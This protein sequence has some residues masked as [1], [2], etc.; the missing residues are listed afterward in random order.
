[1]LRQLEEELDRVAPEALLLGGDLI[2]FPIGYSNL[3]DWVG[4]LSSRFPVM[5]VPGNHDRWAGV[6]RLKRRLDRVHW[7]DD[8]PLQLS[9]GLRLCGRPDQGATSSSLLVG[10]EPDRVAE[11]A[12]YGFPL[13]LA[14]H[15]HG[16]QWIAYQSKGLDYPGAWFFAH[17]G[18]RFQVGPTTL[19]VSRGI[20]DTLP[21]RIHCP[22]DYLLLELR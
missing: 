5:A 3:I 2:D 8:S 11:A 22:R 13:M 1:M 16:C 19:H 10:H 17:H 14:G 18:E 7:L 20:S 4:R 15:L 9:N 21:I 6:G 12:H